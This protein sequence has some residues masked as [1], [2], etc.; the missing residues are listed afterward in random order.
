[1]VR[2]ISLR[3]HAEGFAMRNAF[4]SRSAQH[5]NSTNNPIPAASRARMPLRSRVRQFSVRDVA[6]QRKVSV[7]SPSTILPEQC[8]VTFG[9]ADWMLILNMIHPDQL[10]VTVRAFQCSLSVSDVELSCSVPELDCNKMKTGTKGLRFA[11]KFGNRQPGLLSMCGTFATKE[12]RSYA[13]GVLP[14][15]EPVRSRKQPR[16]LVRD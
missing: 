5:C 16:F 13:H 14:G 9:C 1:M 10:V 6:M 3:T 4:F 15:V 7:S 8:S 11:T 2:S 12:L